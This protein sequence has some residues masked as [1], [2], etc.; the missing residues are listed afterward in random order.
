MKLLSAIWFIKDEIVK[1][2]K[3]HDPNKAR[4]YDMMSI[5]M[6]NVCG[7]SILKSLQ[8]L[9]KSCNERRKA[10]VPDHRKLQAANRKLS[11]DFVAACF[12]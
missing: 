8:L 4:I 12:W 7:D 2:I 3:N 1:F 6:L 9:F 11:S 5:C 10:N